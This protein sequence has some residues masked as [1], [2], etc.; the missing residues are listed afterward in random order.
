MRLSTTLILIHKP[1]SGTDDGEVTLV[2]KVFEYAYVESFSIRALISEA[3]NTVWDG[4]ERRRPPSDL[5]R[6]NFSAFQG[7]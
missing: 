1:F 3:V 7:L 5:K 6:L 4:L 2:F